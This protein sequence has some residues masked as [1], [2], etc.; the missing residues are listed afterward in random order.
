MVAA[1]RVTSEKPR[2][3]RPMMWAIMLSSVNSD[4]GA[5]MMCLPSR[6]IVARSAIR[7]ISSIRCET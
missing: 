7:K 6:R 5:V 4:I 1:S 3:R 2:E